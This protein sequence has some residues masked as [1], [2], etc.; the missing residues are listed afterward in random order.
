MTESTEVEETVKEE[1]AAT[2][3][4]K[5]EQKIADMEAYYQELKARIAATH[6]PVS[7]VAQEEPAEEPLVEEIPWH[8]RLMKTK[9]PVEESP[10]AFEPASNRSKSPGRSSPLADETETEPLEE[11][12]IEAEVTENGGGS[13]WG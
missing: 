4:D 2:L 13:R 1:P 11:V 10:V 6:Q 7:T 12:K 8:Q 5:E 3:N 9:V